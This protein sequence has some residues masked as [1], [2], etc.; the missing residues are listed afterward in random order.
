MKS[1]DDSKPAPASWDQLEA[2]QRFHGLRARAYDGVIQKFV[3]RVGGRDYE[4]SCFDQDP[5]NLAA[6]NLTLVPRGL[7]CPHC[8][9]LYTGDDGRVWHLRDFAVM[10][11]IAADQRPPI[12]H[13]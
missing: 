12:S 2:G 9:L 5:D 11:L 3:F 4:T 7:G 10:Q 8:G 6:E 13:D 1:N